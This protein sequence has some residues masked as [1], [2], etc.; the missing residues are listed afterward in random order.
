MVQE[1]I[2]HSAE[3]TRR[4]A[5]ELAAHLAPG[6]VIALHGDLG[7]GKTCFI[8]GLAEGLGVTRH[9]HSPTF[10]IVCEHAGRIPL[11]HM[12]LY[13]IRTP[14]E[15]LD[16]GLDE[17]LFGRGVCAIE[18]ADRIETLLPPGTLHITLIPGAGEEDRT[19]RMGGTA[20]K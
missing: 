16:L 15:A 3:E 12:D 19:I 11:Y 8:Q 9:V 1:R 5:R 10:T 6:A 18:W 20:P 2:S 17:Y 7:A 14:D 13:R 4:I